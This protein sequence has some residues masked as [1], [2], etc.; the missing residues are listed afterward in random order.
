MMVP[1]YGLIAEIMLFS[2]GFGDSLTLSQ[3]QTAMYR[4]AS[5]Q[6]SAQDHYD[7]GMRAVK[8]VLVMAGRLKRM[9]P[10][11]VEDITLIRAL[12][13]SN[14]PKFL[15]QDIPLFEA[16]LKDLFPGVV[17]PAIDYGSLK[18]YIEDALVA[19]G[20]QVVDPFVG[21]IIQLHETMVVRHGIM[22]VGV[23]A[24]GKTSTA[25]TLGRTFSKMK[26]DGMTESFV[27]KVDRFTLNPKSITMGELYGEFNLMTLEWTDGIISTIVREACNSVAEG[28]MA[29]KWV[30]CDGP[31]DA[32]WIESMNT[33]HFLFF[34]F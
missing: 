8:S 16:I 22:L 11:M 15:A 34:Y 18:K 23:T 12:R 28:D 17:V 5:E 2:E 32:I 30:C 14:V 33:V 4:L 9:D 24:V 29:K 10:N 13:D 21:K 7:F 25:T 1:D 3:K 6:V 27:E 31:V 19:Q 20:L 26:E